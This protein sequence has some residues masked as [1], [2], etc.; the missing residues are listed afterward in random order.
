MNS[1][2]ILVRRLNL[3]MRFYKARAT[4]SNIILVAKNDIQ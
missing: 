1:D 3:S 4:I 2:G